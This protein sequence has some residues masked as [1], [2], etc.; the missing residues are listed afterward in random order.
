MASSRLV[1]VAPAF[2]VAPREARKS[3][4]SVRLPFG[5]VSLW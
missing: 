4:F 5:S 3:V 2:R 1:T